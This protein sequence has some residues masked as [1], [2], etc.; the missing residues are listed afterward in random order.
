MGGGPTFTVNWTPAKACA[1][2]RAASTR[3]KEIV[4]LC[5]IFVFSLASDRGSILEQP[6]C[7]LDERPPDAI[8]HA[9]VNPPI[10][11]SHD[12]RLSYQKCTGKPRCVHDIKVKTSLLLRLGHGAIAAFFPR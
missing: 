10:H 8:R 11:N 12:A 6:L 7:Q 9:R 5:F 3:I 2:K 1:P 4:S